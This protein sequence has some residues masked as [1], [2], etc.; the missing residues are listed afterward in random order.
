MWNELEQD[1]LV[2]ENIFRKRNLFVSGE[3]FV[4]S[5]EIFIVLWH[6]VLDPKTR[7]NYHDFSSTDVV[8]L[9]THQ[10][11]EHAY[12]ERFKGTHLMKDFD[13]HYLTRISF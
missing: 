8:V 10:I 7:G 2:R 12:V 4:W 1:E 9:S 11:D 6:D 5:D 3:I 13:D